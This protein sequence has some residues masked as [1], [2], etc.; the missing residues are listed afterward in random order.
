[1]ITKNNSDFNI[2][3]IISLTY[4]FYKMNIENKVKN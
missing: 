4:V 2:Y 1:M 3:E